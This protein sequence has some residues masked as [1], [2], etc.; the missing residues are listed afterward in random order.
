[1]AG[2]VAFAL[3]A[4]LLTAVMLLGGE[5]GSGVRRTPRGVDPTE[6]PPLLTPPTSVEASARPFA[7]M[8]RW[9]AP[10]GEA[11]QLV[12]YRDG[13]RLATLEPNRTRF[14]DDSVLP[15]VRYTYVVEAVLSGDTVKSDPIRVKTPPA[16]IG[17]ARLEGTFTVDLDDTSHY[18]FSS[19]PGDIQSGW[20]FKPTCHRGACDVTWK[21]A[22]GVALAGELENTGARY[23]G[24][25]TT[26]LA[27]CGDLRGSGTVTV[28]IEVVKA[29]TVRDAWRA[30]KIVG[31]FVERFPAQLGCVASGADYQVTGT[32]IA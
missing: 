31:T 7:V 24:T 25:A 20:R 23:E 14:A 28:S 8:L 21:D 16:P 22:Q 13:D 15:A 27:S 30:T 1:M 19:F 18:G 6:Q 26:R 11:D 3:V 32:L 12:V 29:E 9:A 4:V 2:L 10:E 17:M 5:E